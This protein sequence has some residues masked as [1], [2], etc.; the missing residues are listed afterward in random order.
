[1]YNRHWKRDTL[2]VKKENPMGA[3]MRV[4]HKHHWT[5]TDFSQQ[6]Q[7]RRCFL[8]TSDW[9]CDEHEAPDEHDGQSK[10]RNKRTNRSTNER[11]KWKTDKQT[12]F[13]R[14]VKESHK[15]TQTNT[16]EKK[17]RKEKKHFY[18]IESKWKLVNIVWWSREHKKENVYAV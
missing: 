13:R 4:V 10:G 11:E 17:T 3:H 6:K 7:Q 15:N 14:K 18:V 1:M 2:C 16:E 8:Y 12:K 9:C 5:Y